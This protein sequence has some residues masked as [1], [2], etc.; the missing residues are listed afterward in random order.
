MVAE[1]KVT[2]NSYFAIKARSTEAAKMSVK[3]KT[4]MLILLE[5][6]NSREK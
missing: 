1:M 5:R 3:K 2:D 6:V 4:Y